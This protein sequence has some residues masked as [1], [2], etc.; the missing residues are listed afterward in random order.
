MLIAETVRPDALTA[1][2]RATWS[3]LRGTAEAFQ[4]PLFSPEFAEAVGR[5]RSDAAVAILR[6]DGRPVGF[7]A[8]HRRP[9]GLARPI[10]AP[11]SD[12]HGLV[13]EPGVDGIEALRLAGL[14]E[15]RFS[16]LVDPHGAF[17]GVQSNAEASY[18]IA[19]GP[20]EAAGVEYMEALRAA[21]PKRFKNLR[22]LTNKL[23]RERGRLALAAPDQD[24]DTFETMFAWKRAQFART[25][26]TDVFAP[27]WTRKLMGS[28]LQ[29]RE[30]QLCGMM[31]TLRVAGRPA[32]MHF[33]VREGER[34]HPWVAAQDEALT[35]YSP[36]QIFL[37]RA[38]EAMPSLG[39]RWYDLAAGHDHFK[40]PFASRTVSIAEG[41]VRIAPSLE[42]EAW[43]LAEIALGVGGV[44]RARRR[45]DQIAAVELTLEGR[46]RSFAHA[47]AMRA[48][49]EAS[50]VGRAQPVLES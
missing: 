14:R 36:G 21:S 8:H 26:L 37:S 29:T 17:H 50:R 24:R 38:V 4:N 30:G 23:Q 34:F 41:Q 15:Y 46:L 45:L 27:A 35:D 25:G 12:Y 18:A 42:A 22:R 19:I 47:L 31:M 13:A 49:R 16:A 7:L 10:G 40:T 43:R 20:G 44:A 48:R 28:L 39:L 3:A 6:R 2:D 33:G 5:V 1:K 32:V 9:H 11:F